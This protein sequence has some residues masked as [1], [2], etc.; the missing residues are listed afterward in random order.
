MAT[1]EIYTWENCP[2]CLR[3]KDLFHQKQI[4][5][6][7]YAIDRD[8]EAQDAMADRANGR[9]TVPQIFIN[10]QPIGGCDDLY[11][12]EATGELDRLLFVYQD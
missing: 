10:D 7:E 3:A 1:V 12:L 11:L 5:W 2:H 4:Q 6:T 9:A 8:E